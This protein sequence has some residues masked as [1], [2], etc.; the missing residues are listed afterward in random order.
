MTQETTQEMTQ[1]KREPNCRPGGRI[2][3]QVKV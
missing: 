1:G 3:G 2:V